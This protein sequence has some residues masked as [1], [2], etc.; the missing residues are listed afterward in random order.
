ME[1]VKLFEDFSND[2]NVKYSGGGCTIGSS[3]K[4]PCDD[5][6]IDDEG[7]NFTIKCT[8]EVHGKAMGI[9]KYSDLVEFA[10]YWSNHSTIVIDN[11]GK[12]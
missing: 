5:T 7:N 2:I 9:K 1:H 4:M 11:I 6:W 12:K 3:E 8:K 10:R